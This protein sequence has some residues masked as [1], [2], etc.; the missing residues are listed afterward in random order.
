[1]KWRIL[2]AVAGVLLLISL[3]PIRSLN[4]PD[5]TVTVVD[6]SGAPVQGALVRLNAKNYSAEFDGHSFDAS[7]DAQ[8]QA[9]FNP[10]YIY[11]PIS[12]RLLVMLSE[13]MSIAHASFGPHAAVMVFDG[14]LSGDV[15]E[16]GYVYSWK[17]SPAS[18]HSVIVLRKDR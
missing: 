17:G 6:A 8:G 3:I 13:R 12:K 7:S 15:V 5:W 18:L 2:S 10:T 1:M 9:H 4:S 11:S 14:P 16:N